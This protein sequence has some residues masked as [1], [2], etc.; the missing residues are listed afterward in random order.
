MGR[1]TTVKPRLAVSGS[2]LRQAASG[3][4]E[5]SRMRDRDAPWRA[6]YRTKRWL[7]LRKAVLLRDGWQC[8]ATGAMLVGKYPADNSAVVDHKVPHRG[9]PAL[10]WDIDNLQAVAKGWHDREKQSLERR[11]LM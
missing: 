1:L 3:E 11:G 9:D 5:R 7:K 6:W 2:R 4:A 10:F 8:Q